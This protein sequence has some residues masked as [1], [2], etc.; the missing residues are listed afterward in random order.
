LS[1]H[2]YFQSFSFRTKEVGTFAPEFVL[3]IV[4]Y[5][6]TELLYSEKKHLPILHFPSPLAVT[7]PLKSHFIKGRQMFLMDDKCDHYYALFA[8][9]KAILK[10]LSHEM[11]LALDDIVLGLNPSPLSDHII[12]YSKSYNLIKNRLTGLLIR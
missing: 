8:S 6:S 12:N 4:L 9:N 1:F 10:G 2:I 5:P 7:F 11:G 3:V